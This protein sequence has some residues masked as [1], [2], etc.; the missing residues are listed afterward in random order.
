MRCSRGFLPWPSGSRGRRPTRSR[1]G[2]GLCCSACTRL[3]AAGSCCWGNAAGYVDAITGEGLSLAF[4]QARVLGRLVRPALD[5]PRVLE[6][7]DAA[8]R[9]VFR[10]YAR[11]ASALVALA[12]RPRLRRVALNRLVERPA[13]FSWLLHRLTAP[14][15]AP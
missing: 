2:Q 7:Y 10:S 6:G 11:L 5:D 13:L 12:R 4:E 8:S 14:R 15:E 1:W 3:S 9:R